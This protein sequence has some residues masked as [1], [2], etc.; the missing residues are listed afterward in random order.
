MVCMKRSKQEAVDERDTNA[1]CGSKIYLWSI[2][3]PVLQPADRNGLCD[4][5]AVD[6]DGYEQ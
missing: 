5:A 4:C 6:R 1:L 2:I 3:L